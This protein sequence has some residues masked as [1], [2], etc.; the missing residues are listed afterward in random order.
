MKMTKEEKRK[1][2][3]R[4]CLIQLLIA[5]A[6]LV[7]LIIWGILNPQVGKILLLIGCV[8]VGGLIAA[9]TSGR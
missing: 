4:S 8:L 5:F 3:R 7:G 2:E 6:I 1:K 9:S